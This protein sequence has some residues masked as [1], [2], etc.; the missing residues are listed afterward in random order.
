MRTKLRFTHG[1]N[2]YEPG[3]LQHHRGEEFV[4]WPEHPLATA[5]GVVNLKK[6]S[7]WQELDYSEYFVDQ[8]RN[9]IPGVSVEVLASKLLDR[10]LSFGQGK[11]GYIR[12]SWPSHPLSNKDGRVCEH[13]IIYWQEHEY[14]EY[15][16]NLLKTRKASIHHKN[17]KRDDNRLENLELRLAG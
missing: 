13:W 9:S 17:G 8:I 14:S 5:A 15:V 1:R 16:Y 7:L 12:W 11:G 4:W 3:N 6:L 2:L 10:P